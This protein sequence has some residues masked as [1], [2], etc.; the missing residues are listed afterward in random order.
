MAR[1]TVYVH[2]NETVCTVYNKTCIDSGLFMIISIRVSIVSDI[3]EN[4]PHLNA[5]NEHSV[6]S[7]VI[8]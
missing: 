4:A 7:K 3:Y 2:T 8:I 1:L 5:Q 6:P